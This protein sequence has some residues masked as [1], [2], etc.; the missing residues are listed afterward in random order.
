MDNSDKI[1]A[2][3]RY[4]EAFEKADIN[5]IKE[6]YAVDAVVED[7]VGTEPHVGIDAICSFYEVGLNAGAKLELTGNPRCAGDTVA[8][9]FKA[10]MPGLEIEIIDVFT[11]NSEGKI[12]SMRAYW[13][14]D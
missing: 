4:V 6:L 12:S 14:F 10:V 11:F 7:P 1:A 9:P 2:V 13:G 3:H 5:I 8:F